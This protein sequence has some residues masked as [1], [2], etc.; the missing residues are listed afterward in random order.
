MRAVAVVDISISVDGRSALY[1][2]MLSLEV[3]HLPRC[4]RS[5]C[6]SGDAATAD[7]RHMVAIGEAARGSSSPLCRSNKPGA[8]NFY[9]CVQTKWSS[10]ACSASAVFRHVQ[11]Q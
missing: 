5:G 7:T 10:I 6:G 3:A 4:S 9:T 8:L 2:V 11:K 1:L